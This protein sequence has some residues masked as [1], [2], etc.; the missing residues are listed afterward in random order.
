[1]PAGTAQIEIA[2]LADVFA[3]LPDQ[4]SGWL[5]ESEQARLA[6]IRVA[7][8]RA[9]YLAG[10]WLTRV[11][12]VR[13]FGGAPARWQLLERKGQAPLVQGHGDALR[14]SISHSGDW[15]AAAVATVAIGIDLEQRPRALDA[16]IE[17][18]LR[19]ADDAAGSLD[20]DALLQRWV[21]K[22]SWIKRSGGSA[23]PARLTRLHLQA[24]T[25]EHAD[26]CIDSHDSFHFSLA[27]AP[28]CTVRWQC[29]FGLIPGPGFA[30]TDLEDE[31]A[32]T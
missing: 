7:R 5:S 9:Q 6:G 10:H 15:I 4:H 27:V 3:G 22:E 16:A 19:N 28:D 25:R 14:V 8:R 29:G 23:L 31:T 32:R 18:L 30:I 20:P 11:L 1:M 12:L 26:V 21:A 13:A 17:P 24:T 2:Q